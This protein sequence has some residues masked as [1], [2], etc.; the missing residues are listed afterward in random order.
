MEWARSLRCCA[1]KMP[2]ELPRSP[3]TLAYLA[4]LRRLLR[5]HPHIRSWLRHVRKM[6]S[7]DLCYWRQLRT[8]APRVSQL[9]R[10]QQCHPLPIPTGAG[11]SAVFR[12]GRF[13]RAPRCL[14]GVTSC[15]P[16]L[17]RAVGGRRRR[18]HGHR[19]TLANQSARLYRRVASPTRRANYTVANNIITGPRKSADGCLQRR[20]TAI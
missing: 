7:G 18:W 1:R 4:H 8:L 19:C 12:S 6:P 2:R 20:H 13:P 5:R 10:S 17:G 9:A 16:S 15:S 11:T 14:S 3:P